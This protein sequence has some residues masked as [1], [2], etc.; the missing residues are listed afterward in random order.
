MA[1]LTR[2]VAVPAMVVSPSPES[3]RILATAASATALAPAGAVS[4]TST[5][6]S[7]ETWPSLHTRVPGSTPPARVEPE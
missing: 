5:D 2:V 1:L 7:P 3:V 6:R 4:V